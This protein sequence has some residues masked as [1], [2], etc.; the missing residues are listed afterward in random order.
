MEAPA[1]SIIASAADVRVKRD[2]VCRFCCMGI[3]ASIRKRERCPTRSKKKAAQ[4]RGLMAQ[5]FAADEF[6][7]T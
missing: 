4:K 5:R 7:A 3:M 6:A 2:R 1:D